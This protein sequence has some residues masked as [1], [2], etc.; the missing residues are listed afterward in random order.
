MQD[1]YVGDV[2]DFGK[3]ALLRKLAAGARDR[4]QLGVIWYRY[5]NETHNGDGRHVAYLDNAAYAAL[6]PGLHMGLAQLV[7]SGQRAIEAVER[8][9]IL[10]DDTLY[11]GRSTAGLLGDGSMPRRRT[12]YRSDWLVGALEATA[13][14]NLVFLDPDNGI[15]SPVASRDGPK[16]GKYAFLEELA[17]F[18]GR[19][20]SLVVYHHLNR[21][22][23]HA[24]QVSALA[25]RLSGMLGLSAR[26]CPVVL[27]RGSCRVFWVV[28]QPNHAAR[29]ADGVTAF[30]EVGWLAHCHVAPEALALP[31]SFKQAA[32]DTSAGRRRT[33]FA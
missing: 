14:A 17:A 8:S 10:P 30:A 1:R 27:R 25:T 12:S 33:G 2:G 7:K 28:A 32:S 26:V 3:Y 4:L 20:Q 9:G 23:P 13:S 21:T 29:L 15:A 5:P 6:D 16:A 24:A 18:W 31:K 11:Y 19:G 22:A